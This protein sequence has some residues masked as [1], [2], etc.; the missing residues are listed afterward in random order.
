MCSVFLL[1]SSILKEWVNL[2]GGQVIVKGK[3][4]TCK[5]TMDL[6]NKTGSIPGNRTQ[7]S[8][9]QCLSY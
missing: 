2:A 7:A 6:S 8:L 4:L 1:F 3:G 9:P 5:S